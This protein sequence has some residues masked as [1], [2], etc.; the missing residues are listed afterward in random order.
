MGLTDQFVK[1]LTADWCSLMAVFK[2][3]WVVLVAEFDETHFLLSFDTRTRY[4]KEG[5]KFCNLL[6]FFNTYST[7]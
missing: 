7:M 2:T 5:L 6:V 1:C 4:Q 3:P